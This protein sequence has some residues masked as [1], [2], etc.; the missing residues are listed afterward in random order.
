[1]KKSL[2]LSA[3]L[4]SLFAAVSA[5]GQQVAKRETTFTAGDYEFR[6]VP[7]AVATGT[8][9][10]SQPDIGRLRISEVGLES[11]K[12]AMTV[13][14][15]TRNGVIR[16]EVIPVLGKTALY[17][18]PPE[19]GLSSCEIVFV[20]EPPNQVRVTQFGECWWFGFGVHAT[21]IYQ[22]IRR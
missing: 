18:S 20:A 22:L 3:L 16:D 7:K 9:V 12:V 6:L 10:S 4:L 1:M 11:M 14:V 21:G 19:E 2:T 17:K 15:A 5:N 8:F 13:E